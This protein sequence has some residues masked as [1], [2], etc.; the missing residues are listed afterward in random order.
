MTG[1]ILKSCALAGIMILLEV[2][3]IS[4]GREIES[5]GAEGDS[6]KCGV[7]LSTY[8]EFFKQ[9]YFDFAHDPWLRAF[10]N[11]PASSEQMYV[12]GVTMYRSYIASAPDGP[13]RE[14]LIDTLML[15]YDRRVENFGDEGNVLGRKGRDLYFYRGTNTEQAQL[16]YKM[17][18]KSLEM[19]G[20]ASQ[21]AVMVMYISSGIGLYKAGKISSMQLFE[22]YL[23]VM[24]ILDRLENRSSRW[25]RTRA[26]INEI[27][28]KEGI[29]SCRSLNDTYQG[30]LE[31][32]LNDPAFLNKVITIYRTAGCDLSDTYTNAMVYLYRL[33]PGPESAHDLAVQFIARNELNR[34][35]NYL[36][37]AVQETNTGVETR[38]EWFY[39]LAVV[40]SAL[41]D[42]CK[43]IAYAREAISLKSNYGQAYFLLGDIY[44]A[45]RNSLGEDFE[46]RTAFW[47]AA[48]MY[49][50]AA[51]LDPSLAEESRQKLTEC[52]LQYPDSETVFFLDIK[53]GD[54]YL[55][56]GCINDSTTVRTRK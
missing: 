4:Q 37:E 50:K 17:M 31:Q 35:A 21:E 14:G 6:S 11:C 10:E 43:A 51:S 29:L 5:Y 13:V 52:A 24:G 39:E 56:G 9:E 28:Q 36:K 40:S 23:A 38:A 34:A 54:S 16:A 47:V 3:A 18:K 48:D 2:P 42:Y 12:D 55:V 33:Q 49:R 20:E 45:S 46:Q 15:V 44:I 22:D 7:Y 30:Q 53:E 19:Q 32:H 27:I 26:T 8:R 25:K 41:E 1:K